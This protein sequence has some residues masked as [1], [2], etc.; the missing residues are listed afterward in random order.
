MKAPRA[1]LAIAGAALLA[2][3][4][5][6]AAWAA[7]EDHRGQANVDVAFG[8]VSFTYRP[9][10]IVVDPG[11]T[12]TFTGLDPTKNYCFTVGA[13]YT[14]EQVATAPDVCTSR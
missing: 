7:P 13:V 4:G 5:A 8:G 12:V 14:Y 6:G 10:D 9:A 3:A 1:R 2:L 11:T